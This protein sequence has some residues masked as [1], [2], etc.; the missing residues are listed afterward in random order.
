M[1]ITDKHHPNDMTMDKVKSMNNKGKLLELAKSQLQAKSGVSFSSVD[2]RNDIDL[3]VG[4]TNMKFSKEEI[5][6]LLGKSAELQ[7]TLEKVES[8]TSN[9]RAENVEMQQR[10]ESQ[11]NY[12]RG[13]FEMLRRSLVF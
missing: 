7:E 12:H 8:E 4:E 11:Y 2:S 1:H 9:L 6:V 10:V 13:S 5:T 3:Y